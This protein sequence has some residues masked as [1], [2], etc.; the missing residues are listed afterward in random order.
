MKRLLTRAAILWSM[1]LV[2]G[3]VAGCSNTPVA[4]TTPPAMTT[5]AA[6][7]PTQAAQ[8]ANAPPPSTSRVAAVSVPAYLDPNSPLSKDR[9]VFFDFDDFSVKPDYAALIE[10]HGKFL[11]AHPAVAIRVEGNT[12]ERGGAEY[13]LALGQRRAEAVSRALKLYGARDAQLEAVSWGKE[14]PRTLGREEAALAQNRR[15]D[16]AYP[17]R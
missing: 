14:K 5:A 13:N 10:R 3:L 7:L 12:D 8:N 9:S 15:A 16:L 6:P 4:T 2:G 17:A 1:F 11:A